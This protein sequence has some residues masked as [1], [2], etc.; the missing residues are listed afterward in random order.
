MLVVEQNGVKV[1]ALLA[2]ETLA[3][4]FVDV[5]AA[6]KLDAGLEL[7][8]AE[9]LGDLER[10]DDL[11]RLDRS[12]ALDATEVAD[13]DA[14]QLAEAAEALDDGAAVVESAAAL[15]AGA[16]QDRDQLGV[17]KRRRPVGDQLFPR[18]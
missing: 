4:V 8:L 6:A 12:D 13:A 7:V 5:G 11:R 14:R 10:G 17:R 9:A 2:A 16:Q 18:A 1:F 3:K 15:I